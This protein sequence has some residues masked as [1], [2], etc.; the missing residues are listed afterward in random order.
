MRSVTRR[1][2]DE[3][4]TCIGLPLLSK[5]AGQTS[6]FGL[7]PILQALN[8]KSDLKTDLQRLALP[9]L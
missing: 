8:R 9:Y 4:A 1:N 5:P 6:L 3:Q 2:Q 7:T